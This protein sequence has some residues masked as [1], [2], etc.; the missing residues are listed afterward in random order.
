MTL[1]GRRLSR[2]QTAGLALLVAAIGFAATVVIG[3]A[4]S[5]SYARPMV[6]VIGAGNGLSILV[7]DGPARLLIA[8]G[9]DPAAFGNALAKTRPL[10][11][12]RIDVLLLAGTTGDVTFLSRALLTANGRHVALQT[13][14]NDASHHRDDRT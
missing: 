14:G 10:G 4:D 2:L 8:S 11:R 12:D 1:F 5:R 13:V 9:D 6:T 7:T 3:A